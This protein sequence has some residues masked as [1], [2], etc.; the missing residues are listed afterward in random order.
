MSFNDKTGV[1]ARVAQG[2]KLA[3]ELGCGPRK[4][5][6]E[7]VGVDLLDLPG[8]DLVGDIFEVLAALPSG[9]V[10]S[11][12]TSHFLEHL[13]ELPRLLLELG[14]V[15][16]S[17]GALTVVVPHFSNPFYFSD[18]THRTP[19]GLYTF[20]YYCRSALFAREVPRYGFEAPFD[21][22]AARLGFKSYPPRY[23]RHAFKQLF[24]LL[25]NSSMYAREFYEENLCWLVPC[26]ELHFELRRQ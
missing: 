12:H 8:V 1:L 16:A 3:L 4:L 23:L 7:S 21:I 25:A 22:T 5:H 6:A 19:F 13:P 11:V 9:C 15:M 18:P 26:Y 20:A 14:R 24:G 17:G 2:E 10:H